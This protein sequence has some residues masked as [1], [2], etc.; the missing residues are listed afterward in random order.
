MVIVKQQRRS[1]F[2]IAWYYWRPVAFL[3][4]VPIFAYCGITTLK[5]GGL[6]LGLFGIIMAVAAAITLGFTVKDM[7]K[8]ARCSARKS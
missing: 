6:L 5:A 2:G 4:C 1:K 7:V 8:E 3:L